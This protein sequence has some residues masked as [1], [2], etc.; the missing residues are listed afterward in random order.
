MSTSLG[1]P[2]RPTV[3]TSEILNEFHRE[4]LSKDAQKCYQA[5]WLRM[6]SLQATEINLTDENL[7]HRARV[8]LPRIHAAKMELQRAGLLHLSPFGVKTRYEFVDDEAAAQ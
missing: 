1:T 2:N 4:L 3:D 6:N 8:V 7:S 5:I